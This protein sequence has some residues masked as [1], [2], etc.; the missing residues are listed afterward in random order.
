V[1]GAG[2]QFSYDANGNLIQDILNNNNEIL[3]DHRNL[4]TK[5]KHR[6]MII[7]DTIFLTKYYYDESGNRIRKMTYAYIGKE[8]EIKSLGKLENI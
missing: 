3:Y 4:I 2:N 1:S 7:G 6:S 8:S 5:L